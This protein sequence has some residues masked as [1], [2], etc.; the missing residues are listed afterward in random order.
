MNLKEVGQPYYSFT[1]K[2]TGE[3]LD[4]IIPVYDNSLRGKGSPNNKFN[5]KIPNSL[6]MHIIIYIDT[7]HLKGK[8]LAFS[9]ILNWPRKNHS[10]YCSKHTL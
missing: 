6:C 3:I 7:E 8:K 9:E 4:S 1:Y 10:I 5:V 2:V